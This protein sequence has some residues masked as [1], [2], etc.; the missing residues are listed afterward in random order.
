VQLR[1]GVLKLSFKRFF[2]VFVTWSIVIWVWVQTSFEQQCRIV[3]HWMCHIHV[4]TGRK[5]DEMSPQ[6][7]SQGE[8]QNLSHVEMRWS[9]CVTRSSRQL[10][11]GSFIAQRAK[12]PRKRPKT[13]HRTLGTPQRHKFPLS[14]CCK[15]S[16]QLISCLLKSK[17]SLLISSNCRSLLTNG[18]CIW[19]R[20]YAKATI[21]S[22]ARDWPI[23]AH[24]DINAV[25]HGMSRMSQSVIFRSFALLN[26]NNLSW[27]SEKCYK[28]SQH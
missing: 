7:T 14:N 19:I 10:C 9:S 16:N 28:G 22:F 1:Y 3:Q 17:R 26:D 2:E 23:S 25:S 5:S 11:H 21:V 13:L 15:A 12:T 8:I 4:Y 24:V 18:S 27:M 20:K 6:T